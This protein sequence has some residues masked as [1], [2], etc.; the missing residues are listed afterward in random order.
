[1]DDCSISSAN[2]TDIPD[3]PF[4]DNITNETLHA[5]SSSAL[6]DISLL[7]FKSVSLKVVTASTPKDDA[8][9]VAAALAA[10]IRNW[11]GFNCAVAVAV[12]VA[13]VAVAVVIAVAVAAVTVVVVADIDL[14]RQVVVVVVVEVEVEVEVEV[15]VVLSLPIPLLL[16]FLL[17]VVQEEAIIRSSSSSST[18]LSLLLLLLVLWLLVW[19][20]WMK[21]IATNN[22]SSSSDSNNFPWTCV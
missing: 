22:L 10:C 13:A 17:F 9:I 19:Y 21:P 18:F 15:V 20:S 7:S 5:S 3:V 2:N 12:A 4:L 6:A 8:S 16:L 11:T 1:L 14:S